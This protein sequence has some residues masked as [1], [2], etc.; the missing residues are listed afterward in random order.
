VHT[1]AGVVQA[2]GTQF[3]VYDRPEGVDVSVLEGRV[4]L[5]PSTA[6]KAG[7]VTGED[8]VAGEQARIRLD[9]T[10]ERAERSD[11]ERAIAWSR[12]RLKF[13]NTPLDEI[14]REFNRYHQ[15]VKLRTEGIPPHSH[16]YTGIFDAGDPGTL[17]R[18]LE[19]EPDLIVERN[20]REILIRP[21][22]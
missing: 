19:Q 4:R 22:L 11:V 13:D 5:T 8:L 3:N 20:G 2:I 14:V 18:F 16:R 15:N 21:R 17:A 10:I 6:G 1:R 9:G 12:R 7:D